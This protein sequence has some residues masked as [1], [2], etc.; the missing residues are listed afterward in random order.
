MLWLD[1]LIFGNGFGYRSPYFDNRFYWLSG[2]LYTFMGGLGAQL[3]SCQWTHPRAG[4]V[5][6]LSGREYRPFHSN[7]RWG[8]VMVAWATKLPHDITAANALLCKIKS[9]LGEL[10]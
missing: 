9:E 7:R 1:H 6:M 3:H 5:R 2:R 4:E 8:R 10:N